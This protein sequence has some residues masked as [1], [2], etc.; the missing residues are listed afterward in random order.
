MCW[1]GKRL[2]DADSYD[3]ANRSWVASLGGRHCSS[4]RLVASRLFIICQAAFNLLSVPDTINYSRQSS[5][6][7]VFPGQFV[8]F[9]CDVSISLDFDTCSPLGLL[10]SFRLPIWPIGLPITLPV[11]SNFILVRARES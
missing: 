4:R 9:S 5:R 10:L 11:K 1:V 6:I 8:A 3:K 2:R 7:A